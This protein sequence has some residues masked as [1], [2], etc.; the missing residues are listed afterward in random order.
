M[1]ELPFPHICCNA[2]IAHDVSPEMAVIRSAVEIY[3]NKNKNVLVVPTNGK[4]A[5]FLI[6]LG[7]AAAGPGVDLSEKPIISVT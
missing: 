5:R 7:E 2:V 6:G 3:K 1:N 4:E